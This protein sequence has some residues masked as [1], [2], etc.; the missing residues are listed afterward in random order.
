[1]RRSAHAYLVLA[2]AIAALVGQSGDDEV[3]LECVSG[4]STPQCP[5]GANNGVLLVAKTTYQNGTS[6]S[7]TVTFS[8]NVNR[9]YTQALS[10][11][12]GRAPGYQKGVA[13]TSSP[14]T[15][16]LQYPGPVGL[17]LKIWVLCPAEQPDGTCAPLDSGLQDY[18]NSFRTQSNSALNWERV[19]VRLDKAETAWIADETQ[20]QALTPYKDF[21]DD[22]CEDLYNKVS[23]LSPKKI[24]DGAVNLYLV[25]TV[26]GYP[27]KAY[28]CLGRH[29]AVVG[30]SADWTT[31]LHE[32]G[33]T[34]A[35]DDIDPRESTWDYDA[36]RN[37]MYS[38]TD[39][40][41]KFYTEGQT[42]RIHFNRN[43]ALNALLKL[44]PADERYCGISNQDAENETP[45]CPKLEARIW[46]DQ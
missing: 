10:F 33:H 25:L 15:V 2:A 39:Q 8:G 45:P 27:N 42:F 35:L 3:K 38:N 40:G 11:R 17:P 24:K 26:N 34:L 19:G 36:K 29:L 21:D 6:N 20:N 46:P 4:A 14:N 1:V 32:I 28:E 9:N 43:S 13:W 30:A 18:L 44:R 5:S 12:R 7:N 22:K 16:T 23:S 37:F 41:R 31:M